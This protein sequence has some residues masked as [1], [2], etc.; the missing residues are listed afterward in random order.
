MLSPHRLAPPIVKHSG[1]YSSINLG[2]S[3]L[4]ATKNQVQPEN[5]LIIVGSIKGKYNAGAA[6]HIFCI[7]DGHQEEIIVTVYDQLS[8]RG[9]IVYLRENEQLGSV[10]LEIKTFVKSFEEASVKRIFVTFTGGATLS[11]NPLASQVSAIFS[12][13]KSVSMSWNTWHWLP[14]KW[15]LCCYNSWIVKLDLNNGNV[16]SFETPFSQVNRFV[17]QSGIL[18]YSRA[19]RKNKSN[20]FVDDW[21]RHHPQMLESKPRVTEVLKNNSQ[22]YVITFVKPRPDVDSYVFMHY[23]NTLSEMDEEQIFSLIGAG[24]INFVILYPAHKI[25]LP[26]GQERNADPEGPSGF[27]QDGGASSTTLQRKGKRAAINIAATKPAVPARQ[28]APHFTIIESPTFKEQISILQSFKSGAFKAT[29]SRIQS[30]Y[31]DLQSGRLPEKTVGGFYVS[32]VSGLGGTGRGAWRLLIERHGNT[33]TLNCIADYHQNRWK[34][35]S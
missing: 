25:V 31:Q 13:L 15:R 28:Q 21:F 18:T 26:K 30:I 22:G 9:M 6:N 10:F 17:S 23:P 27:Q 16:K 20:D 1:Y 32:D 7:S 24:A 19:L 8:K 14:N 3:D 11:S 34:V 35:W 5:T 12:G 33:L 2:F 4:A 29:L